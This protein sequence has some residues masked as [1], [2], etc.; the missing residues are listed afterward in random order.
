MVNESTRDNPA[1]AGRR[2]CHH[3]LTVVDAHQLGRER[4]S[5]ESS[6]VLNW[7]GGLAAN[8]SLLEWFVCGCLRTGLS[9]D[10]LAAPWTARANRVLKVSR[11]SLCLDGASLT[12]HGRAPRHCPDV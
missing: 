2:R 4:P 5:E 7:K 3:R 11:P 12:A 9:G 10:G 8:A 6:I 1:G